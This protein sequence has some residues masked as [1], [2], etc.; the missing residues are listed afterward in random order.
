MAEISTASSSKFKAKAKFTMEE[1]KDQVLYQ[2]K[3]RKKINEIN[4]VNAAF[5]EHAQEKAPDFVAD[6]LKAYGKVILT[7]KPYYSLAK[8]YEI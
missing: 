7:K 3:Y 4:K 2:R 8:L 1:T 5:M 6:F